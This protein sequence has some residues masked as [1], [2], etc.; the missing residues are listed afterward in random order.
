MKMY[1]HDK[2][3]LQSISEGAKDTKLIEEKATAFL[4]P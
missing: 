2:M 3:V 4:N 1:C